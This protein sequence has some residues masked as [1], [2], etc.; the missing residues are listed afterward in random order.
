[1]VEEVC[2][3]AAWGSE[4][5]SDEVSDELSEE[6]A[7][8]SSQPLAYETVFSAEEIGSSDE[9]SEEAADEGSLAPDE[10]VSGT[11]ETSEETSSEEAS[12][13]SPESISQ[14]LS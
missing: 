3:D 2:E 10:G 5:A 11:E 7:G 8:G 13:E 4:E 9:V 14:A 12:L 6:D 1:M